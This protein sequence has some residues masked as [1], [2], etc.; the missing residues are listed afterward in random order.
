M[1]KFFAVISLLSISL[2]HICAQAPLVNTLTPTSA[3]K[4]TIYKSQ[5]D[6]MTLSGYKVKSGF[7]LSSPSGGLISDNKPGKVVFSLK[8][9]YSKLSF[10]IGPSYNSSY[11]ASSIVTISAD[12]K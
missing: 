9:A 8:G 7:S 5:G 12:G 10:V 1:K 4:C 11:G 6:A 2:I 3:S